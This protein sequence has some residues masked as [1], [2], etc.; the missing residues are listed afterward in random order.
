MKLEHALDVIATDI[1]PTE[2]RQAFFRVAEYIFAHKSEIEHLSY[3][4]IAKLAQIQVP[5][6]LLRLTQYLA[7]ERVKL[8]EMKFE[9]VIDNDITPLDDETIYHAE[10]SGELIH[11]ETGV[12]IENYSRHVYPY[13]V[14]S[15]EVSNG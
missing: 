3:S 15:A 11:P 6:Q 12:P 8:L 9:L 13:F 2:D 10:T 7:G 1:K 5:D 4:A 14:V